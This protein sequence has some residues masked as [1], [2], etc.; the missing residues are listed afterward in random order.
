MCYTLIQFSPKFV[1]EGPVDIKSV[2]IQ[3]IA[4]RVFGAKLSSISM[5]AY[6]LLIYA[7][8][9]LSHLFWTNILSVQKQ[10]MYTNWTVSNFM[11]DV[12]KNKRPI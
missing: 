3:V 7:S 10:N 8:I 2:F 5:M 9:N 11:F 6:F 4:Y 12:V 1:H